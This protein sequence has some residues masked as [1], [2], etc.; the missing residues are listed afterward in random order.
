[1]TRTASK[2]SQPVLAS[3]RSATSGPAPSRAARTRATSV[4]A[5]VP[6]LSLSVR[7]PSATRA[8]A[9]SAISS[10]SPDRHA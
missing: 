9:A 1:M 3:T 7:K 8:R 5:S 2:Q 10:G 4:A 6:T